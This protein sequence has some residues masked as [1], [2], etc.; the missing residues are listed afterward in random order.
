M[1][2]DIKMK[3]TNAD[4]IIK[5]IGYDLA[6]KYTIKRKKYLIGSKIIHIREPKQLQAQKI[7]TNYY[8]LKIGQMV[9][10]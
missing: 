10:F 4:N 6:T 7:L 3:Y 1:I 5:L 9:V 2:F 8:F